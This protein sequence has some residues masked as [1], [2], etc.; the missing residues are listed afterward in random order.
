M[1]KEIRAGVESTKRRKTRLIEVSMLRVRD[2]HGFSLDHPVTGVVIA[3]SKENGVPCNGVKLACSLL[4]RLD[5]PGFEAEWSKK[6]NVGDLL[7]HL[8]ERTEFAFAER[9][10]TI[11]CE[12]RRA[13]RFP[14]PFLGE[15]GLHQHA[16][17]HVDDCFVGSFG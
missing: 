6:S 9:G 15:T 12:S 4:R 13:H 8:F 7:E 5:D 10:E 16:A 2:L 1:G 14:P 3:V 11:G 17:G